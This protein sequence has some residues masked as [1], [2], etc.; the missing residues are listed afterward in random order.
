[1]FVF[2]CLHLHWNFLS[3]MTFQQKKPDKALAM[4]KLCKV[5]F[6]YEWP[7]FLLSLPSLIIV[8]ALA[9]GRLFKHLAAVVDMK[10]LTVH[11]K[12]TK[13]NYSCG[14]GSSLCYSWR[15][16]ICA[17]GEFLQTFKTACQ[18]AQKELEF[19]S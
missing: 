15:D 1:M 13:I 10:C 17:S 7:M 12:W 9:E 8:S 19:F 4:W 18:T 14:R 3:D 11:W 5:G 2:A 6:C 16:T